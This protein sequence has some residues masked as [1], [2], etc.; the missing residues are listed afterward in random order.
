MYMKKF[1]GCSV[2]WMYP[3][4]GY[5]KCNVSSLLCMSPHNDFV[6]AYKPTI[7]NAFFTD[8]EDGM[9]CNC[10]PECSRITYNVDVEPI[11]DEKHID[12]NFV[13]LNVHFAKS[14]MIKYRTDVTFSWM[15]LMVGFGGIVSLF[16]GC[17]LLSG[18]EIFYFTTIAL[19]WHRHRSNLSRMKLVE[20]FK[21]RF[22]FTH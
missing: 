21:A 10:L 17:S 11:Y 12:K 1:C 5:L 20:K 7:K 13:L 22:P 4:I 8:D 2:D 14:T 15:D 3:S 16:L 18:F 19:F 6:N 9:E